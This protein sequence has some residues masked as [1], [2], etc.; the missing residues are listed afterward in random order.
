MYMQCQFYVGLRRI[1]KHELFVLRKISKFMKYEGC[2]EYLLHLT[3]K[4]LLYDLYYNFKL[5]NSRT[6]VSSNWTLPITPNLNNG[7]L[8]LGVIGRVQLWFEI[9]L[10][11]TRRVN[12]FGVLRSNNPEWLSERPI[13]EWEWNFCCLVKCLSSNE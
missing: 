5:K 1:T 8:W 9:D 11:L 2:I 6:M 3:R 12:Q 13:Y 7:Y 4:G 10:S